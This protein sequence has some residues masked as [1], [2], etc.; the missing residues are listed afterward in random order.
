MSQTVHAQN[1]IP[2]PEDPNADRPVGPAMLK[3]WRCK[4]PACGEGKLF[5]GYLTVRREC[6]NCREEL[7]HQRADDGP[8][9]ATL[10]VTGHLLAPLM[11]IMWDLWQPSPLVMASTLS[12]FIVAVSLFLLPRFKGTFVGLQWSRRMHGFGAEGE[13]PPRP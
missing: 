3:G 5:E 8:A 1:S 6:P 4:C 12:V 11:L 10:V 2:V 13:A 7:Y 9:W